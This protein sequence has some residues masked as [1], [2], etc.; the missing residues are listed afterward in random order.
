MSEIDP[1]TLRLIADVKQAQASILNLERTSDRSF[2]KLERDV[3]RVEA[4]MKRSSGA[5]GNSLRGLAGTLATLFTGR[6]LVGLIDGFT[7]LQN[8]LRVSGLEGQALENVQSRLLDLSTR[9][10]VSIGELAGLYGKSAQSAKELGASE[11]ELLQLTEASAQALKISGTSAA[12]AQ[13]AL[14]GLTQALSSG[15]VRAEEYNQVLEG[16]L[17]PL[18]QIVANTDKYGGSLG[19]LRQ[20]V[21]DGKVSSAEFYQAILAGSAELDAKASKATLTLAGAFEALTSRLTVYVGQSAQANGATAALAGGLQLLADNIDVLIPALATV[22]TFVGTRMVAAAIAGSTA[23]A[24]FT[25][26]LAGTASASAL[27]TR[28]L[29]ALTAALTGPAGVALAVTAVV[30]SFAY[31][32]TSADSAA[33]SVEGLKQ[34]NADASTELDRMI[35]RLKAAGVQT[36]EL[37]AAADRARGPIDG[38]ADSFRQA[39]IE[40]RKF[41]A[42]VGATGLQQNSADITASQ[43][44][45]AT[46]REYIRAQR[47][48][49][50][51]AIREG[52]KSPQLVRAEDQLAEEVR[53]EALLRAQRDVRV[54]GM[55]AGVD[56]DNDTP[57]RSTATPTA[58]P[59]RT[60]AG[61]A[62]A[63]TDPLDA[64][65]RNEQELRALQLEEI[66]AKE[67]VAT[68]ATARADLARQGLALEA[69]M[70]RKDIDEAVRKKTLTGEEANAR[71]AMI[72]NLYG[73]ADEITVQGRET[74]YQ[75]AISREEQQR[76]ARQQ[77]DAMRDELDA[78]GAEAGI[79][80]VRTA[81]V[82]I[83]RRMLEIQQTIERALLDE[84]IARGD[85]LDAAQARAALARKQA[86][87]RTGFDRDNQG[88]LGQYV[89]DLRKAGLNLDDQFEGIAVNG[90][91]SLND[92][93]ADA[94]ANSKNLG[95]VF[96]NVANQIIAD[97]I[98]IAIQQTI[99][100]ALQSA[101]GGGGGGG[102]GLFGS[103]L[104]VAG[105]AAKF[106]GKT[107]GARAGGGPVEGGQLYRVNEAGMEYFQ[108]AN[109]GRII[110]IGEMNRR[111]ATPSAQSSGIA[112]V[113]VELSGDLD[114]RI[115]NVSGP[116]AVEV[117]SG[118]ARP[119]IEAAAQETTR[120]MSRPR[121]PGAGR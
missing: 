33:N 98:R 104:N 21:V 99:V 105:T 90:L 26:T 38:L 93:L 15:T 63:G 114:A 116:V 118:A 89:E 41:N 112:T 25:A 71:R 73:A 101:F 97:L 76:I 23:Y 54:A 5:I 111:L 78:L 13:G 117:V 2:S 37:A 51:G 74:A 3:L 109:S 28:G 14:L 39:L 19:K 94:I 4:Q 68:S 86:A 91:R 81:R 36:D 18:L 47:A 120:R 48:A 35:G 22:A 75:L 92:G 45:Q 113:R 43:G 57:A 24:S 70:R 10:G 49:N 31:F 102:G 61:R 83:E 88:P 67:Q 56:V 53:R 9:Y 82:A 77:T 60:R 69:E 12:Q 103:I 32:S 100:N 16:G 1:L 64:V 6:E 110:P 29:A 44:R 119:I 42:E 59:S 72:D 55:R 79:T 96:K 107:P 85:V 66:R 52:R 40:A 8:S 34:S 84:A 95:D 27:A 62:G 80:D 50:P 20:A 106:A 121:M 30:A 87:V 115:V 17:Q 11:A 46:L 58:K 65:F 108:P 7:R